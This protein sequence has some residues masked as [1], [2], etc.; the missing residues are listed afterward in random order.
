MTAYTPLTNEGQAVTSARGALR[1]GGTEVCGSSDGALV[2][3]EQRT[4]GGHTWAGC[5]WQNPHLGDEEVGGNE[6]PSTHGEL[7]VD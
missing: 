2:V 6:R 1:H 7:R 3:R 4:S 5:N